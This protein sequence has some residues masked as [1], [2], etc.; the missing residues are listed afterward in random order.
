VACPHTTSDLLKEFILFCKEIDRL[1]LVDAPLAENMYPLGTALKVGRM[2]LV[3]ELLPYSDVLFVWG[4]NDSYLSLLSYFLSEISSHLSRDQVIDAAK[5]LIDQ[6]KRV[7]QNSHLD[8]SKRFPSLGFYMDSPSK[9]EAT[10]LQMAYVMHDDGLMEYILAAGASPFATIL[11]PS[12]TTTLCHT[13][14]KEN[15]LDELIR[16]LQMT[17][18]ANPSSEIPGMDSSVDRND[19]TALDLACSTGNMEAVKILLKFGA[20]MLPFNSSSVFIR[21]LKMRKT[22]PG[23]ETDVLVK[24]LF[25]GWSAKHTAAL[26]SPEAEEHH[27]ILM[28]FMKSQS[29][30]VIKRYMKDAV[31]RAIVMQGAVDGLRYSP[32]LFELVLQLRPKKRTAGVKL[33]SAVEFLTIEQLRLILKA[34]IDVDTLND[35]GI[36]VHFKLVQAANIPMLTVLLDARPMDLT[37]ERDPEGNSLLHWSVLKTVRL[38]L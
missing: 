5:E 12:G 14:I 22:S 2:D 25:S 35:E 4:D 36:T 13:F 1:D 15:N 24:T 17:K 20:S 8:Q 29:G 11:G 26:L 18:E 21:A 23:R 27:A 32:D 37:K 10:P 19:Q 30:V 9:D 31:D 34:G 33:H 16:L 28:S 38:I 3:R 7:F 6:A